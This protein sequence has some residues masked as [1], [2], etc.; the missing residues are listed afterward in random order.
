[1]TVSMNTARSTEWTC[2]CIKYSN[3]VTSAYFSHTLT[4][5]TVFYLPLHNKLYFFVLLCLRRDK[6]THLVL[7]LWLAELC[8]CALNVTVCFFS[9]LNSK[10]L[11][12]SASVR[13]ERAF[14]ISI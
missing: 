4:E 13:E 12:F 8:G 3:V 11:N 1:M 10:L 14:C 5:N 2:S 9:C 7:F 6:Y